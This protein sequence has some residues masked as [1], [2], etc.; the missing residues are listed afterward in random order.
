MANHFEIEFTVSI[1]RLIVGTTNILCIGSAECTT[2]NAFPNIGVEYGEEA[3]F[4]IF[5][6]YHRDSYDGISIISDCASRSF[7]LPA[8]AVKFSLE[9]DQTINK[10]NVFVNG[11]LC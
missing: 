5:M 8:T 10:F 1:T 7:S 3:E 11:H 6:T 4:K 2:Y 9:I